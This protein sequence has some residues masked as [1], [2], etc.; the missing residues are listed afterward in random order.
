[1]NS[2]LVTGSA[3]FIGSA[4]CLKLLGLGYTVTGIDNLNSYYDINLKKDRLKRYINNKRY[5]H[6][7]IDIDNQKLL[8]DVFSKNK[9]DV[10]VNLAAQAGVRYSSINPQK[11]I[12]SNILGFTN[13]LE[14]CRKKNIKH[15]VY[16][17]SSSVY[18]LNKKIPFSTNQKTNH[19][20]SVYA[21]TKKSNELLAHTYSH[22]YNMPTT[23]LRFFTVYG[24]WGRPDMALH[25]FA[26]SIIKNKPIKLFNYGKHRRDFTYIDDVVD[27]IIKVLSKPATPDKKWCAHN[28]DPSSSESPYKIYNIGN[29]TIVEIEKYINILEKELGQRAKKELFPLQAGDIEDT[30]ADIND[31]IED[32]NYQ[33]TTTV[34]KGIKEFVKWYKSYYRV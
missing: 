5:N 30:L 2:A 1:M 32:F 19:P 26:E 6:F 12:N 23:G 22:L 13:V 28:P 9:F 31:L 25:L 15:L 20:I 17:S 16:A 4:L 8:N 27:G 7:E 11:Y 33:P 34:E 14:G 10:V 3:G 24:P 21:A 18:G 29:N